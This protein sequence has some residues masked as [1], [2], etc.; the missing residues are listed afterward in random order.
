[1][2]IILVT[3]KKIEPV[4]QSKEKNVIIV[5]QKKHDIKDPMIGPIRNQMI[6]H[7]LRE[8]TEKSG[9]GK[10]H[11]SETRQTWEKKEYRNGLLSNRE[12]RK[13]SNKGA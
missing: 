6:E 1:M 11:E 9:R 8:E 2:T 3:P 13:S 7:K 4:P 10:K 5:D 12:T